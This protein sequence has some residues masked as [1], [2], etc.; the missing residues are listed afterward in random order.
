MDLDLFSVAFFF[1]AIYC[2]TGMDVL[3]IY[4]F[5]HT[6]PKVLLMKDL[7]HIYCLSL[8]PLHPEVKKSFTQQRLFFIRSKVF[9]M[10][11]VP[12]FKEGPNDLAKILKVSSAP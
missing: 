9:E 5:L 11:A 3:L 2:I 7:Y 8:I 12:G 10:F 4:V 1:R 6:D